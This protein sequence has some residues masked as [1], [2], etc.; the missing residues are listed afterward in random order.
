M[1]RLAVGVQVPVTLNYCTSCIHVCQDVQLHARSITLFAIPS[2][3]GPS[4][5]YKHNNGARP[6]T[7]HDGRCG[8]PASLHCDRVSIP[9]VCRESSFW[10]IQGLT[11]LMFAVQPVKRNSSSDHCISVFS[12]IWISLTRE[13]YKVRQSAWVHGS[14][15]HPHST[16]NTHRPCTA[17]LYYDYALTFWE[18]RSKCQNG[19]KTPVTSRNTEAL[20]YLSNS[21]VTINQRCS[22]GPV[23]LQ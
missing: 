22:N 3:L 17:L 18:R 8:I 11:A 15:M 21:R 5:S 20:F 4:S 13:G 10:D 6:K 19:S 14:E 16:Y 7:T 23:W 12:K 9:E 2:P 1:A